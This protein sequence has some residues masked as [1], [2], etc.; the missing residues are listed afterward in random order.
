MKNNFKNKLNNYIQ[1]FFDK[2]NLSGEDHR[3]FQIVNDTILDYKENN[4]YIK[5]FFLLNFKISLKVK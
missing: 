2:D 5:I 3:I 1:D 4:E